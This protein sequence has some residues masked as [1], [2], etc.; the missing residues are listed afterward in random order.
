MGCAICL[1][2][3]IMLIKG[4]MWSILLY[5][6]PITQFFIRTIAHISSLLMLY[7]TL[8]HGYESKEKEQIKGTFQRI[9]SRGF[10]NA[11]LEAA[12]VTFGEGVKYL[13]PACNKDELVFAFQNE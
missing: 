2:Q 9:P 11:F 12:W 8:I 3:K 10:Y 1:P 6:I 7:C 5:Q 4:H 13:V